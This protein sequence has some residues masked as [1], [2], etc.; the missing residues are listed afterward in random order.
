MV[1]KLQADYA[2]R[3]NELLEKARAN[4]G[5]SPEEQN[6]FSILQV[7]TIQLEAD[8]NAAIH[9]ALMSGDSTERSTRWFKR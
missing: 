6:E 1:S 4:G 2:N 8:R 7:T 3:A 9:N 5:L